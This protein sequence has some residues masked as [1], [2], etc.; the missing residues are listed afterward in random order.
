MFVFVICW[1]AVVYTARVVTYTGYG[2]TIGIAQHCCH[3]WTDCC[4]HSLTHHPPAS[5]SQ[6][7]LLILPW[8]HPTTDTHHLV[9]IAT[10][11]NLHFIV[12]K[13]FLKY[14]NM[15]LHSSNKP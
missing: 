4:V 9:F 10:D 5:S 7:P 8:Y 3:L 12:T 2:H 1:I 13:D 15:F 14:E 11:V 6:Q